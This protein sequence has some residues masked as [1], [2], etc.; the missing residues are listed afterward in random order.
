MHYTWIVIQTVYYKIASVR[1]TAVGGLIVWQAE[2][3]AETASVGEPEIWS[4]QRA[5]NHLEE[6][7]MNILSTMIPTM[8]G[9]Q[10]QG[11]VYSSKVRQ[12]RLEI[13]GLE[14]QHKQG[15]T[16]CGHRRQCARSC[17]GL[18]SSFCFSLM[19][20]LQKLDLDLVNLLRSS[21]W[22]LFPEK[23]TFLM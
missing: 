9:H 4:G 20:Q 19:M 16:R 2:T 10:S 15:L 7:K 21:K 22:K 18:R 11:G 5:Q 23:K 17:I 3:E 12:K 8:P 1:L 13:L 6:Q 14:R